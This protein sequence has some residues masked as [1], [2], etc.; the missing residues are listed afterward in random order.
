MQT[1]QERIWPIVKMLVITAILT[2]L[3]KPVLAAPASPT[4][5]MPQSSEAYPFREA[6]SLAPVGSYFAHAVLSVTSM[7]L[8]QPTSGAIPADG[9]F[10][11]DIRLCNDSPS[12]GSFYNLTWNGLIPQPGHLA[13]YDAN[14][15]H[16]CD[17]LGGNTAGSRQ[18]IA[19]HDWSIVPG[20]GYTGVVL[21]I[22]LPYLSDRVIPPGKY[23]LQ[24]VYLARFIHPFSESKT[25]LFY[26]SDNTELFRSNAVPITVTSPLPAQP[27]KQG[28]AH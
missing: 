14:K 4:N 18:T 27:A 12:A 15:H 23:F 17:L 21:N 16:V 6:Y 8:R 3:V 25:S 26:D 5:T 11:V 19:S 20:S 9:Q 24:V 1:F 28:L 2:F 7:Q 22:S 10:S 13:L